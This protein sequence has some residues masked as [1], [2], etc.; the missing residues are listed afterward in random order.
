MAKTI[1]LVTLGCPKNIADSRQIRGMLGEAGF[2]FSENAD[3]AD[4]W[5]VNTCGFVDSAKEESIRAILELAGRKGD[6]R[7]RR[8]IVT[9]CLVQK[10]GEELAAELPEVDLFLGTGSLPELAAFLTGEAETAE[11][12]T[13]TGVA[14]MSAAAADVPVPGWPG[15][16]SGESGGSRDRLRAG[17]PEAYLF[18]DRWISGAGQ[19]CGHVEYVK[20]AEGC[21]H[22]CTYCVIPTMRGRYRSRS[23]DSILREAETLVSGGCREMILVAQD[24]SIYGKDIGEEQALRR[25]LEELEKIRELEWIRLLYYYP[26][27]LGDD[28]LDWMARSKKLCA[29]LD[30]PFQHISDPILKRMGRPVSS[31]EIYRLIDRVRGAV[32]GIILRSTFIVGFP[33]ETEARFQELLDFLAETRLDRAGFF[34]FSPQPGTPAAAMPDPVDSEIKEDRLFRAE[35]LQGGILKMKQGALIGRNLEVMTDR[36]AEGEHSDLWEGRTRGDAPDID[37]LVYFISNGRHQ[38]GEIQQI[39]ITHTQD[40]ALIGELIR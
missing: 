8:L 15:R 38:P 36:R 35:S 31:G 13:A 26:E 19:K 2:V 11:T 22:I 6:R 14:E 27:G 7:G 1:K 12:E 4:V 10:Y 32:P 5:V 33:G 16:S 40:F 28:L 39:H 3:E 20:I 30:L 21:N 29:Y 24:T 37:G 23:M 25:L 17:P 34:V 9:G 18:E